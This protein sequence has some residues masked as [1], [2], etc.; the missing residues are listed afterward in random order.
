MYLKPSFPAT[1]VLYWIHSPSP[2]TVAMSTIVATTIV[3]V[4][5]RCTA[6]TGTRKDTNLIS[7]PQRMLIIDSLT[8]TH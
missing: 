8:R 5:R 3:P 4:T 1:L 7:T 6:A 2:I